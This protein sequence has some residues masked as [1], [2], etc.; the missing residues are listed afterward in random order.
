M[1]SISNRI[2]QISKLMSNFLNDWNNHLLILINTYLKS[3]LIYISN[4]NYLDLIFDLCII[5][6]IEE[7]VNIIKIHDLLLI[8]F[9]W[10]VFCYGILWMG[11]KSARW[12]MLSN[13]RRWTVTMMTSSKNLIDSLCN[14]FVIKQNFNAMKTLNISA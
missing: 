13:C 12:P 3:E 4:I 1:L 7:L 9:N 11:S 14:S 2:N 6:L 5:K 8:R 10:L